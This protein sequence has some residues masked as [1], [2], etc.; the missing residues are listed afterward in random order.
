MNA[1]I[2]P[3][4]GRHALK[5]RAGCLTCKKRRV[6]CDQE[7]P[8]CHRCSKASQVCGGCQLELI[9]SALAQV[10]HSIV[11]STSTTP[12][13]AFSATQQVWQTYGFNSRKVSSGLSGA[14]DTDLWQ[15]LF[16]KVATTELPVRLALFALGTLARHSE[17]ENVQHISNCLCTYCRQTLKYYDRSISSLS[18]YLQ[19]T[20]ANDSVDLALVSC[21]LFTCIELYRTND[22]N[23]ITLV[24]KGSSILSQ[25]TEVNSPRCQPDPSLLNFVQSPSNLR[26]HV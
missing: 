24:E 5:P 23:A 11:I 21:V 19:K 10:S 22:R 9:S 26:G 12:L 6:K 13:S 8:A 7:R 3:N 1:N 14:F 18:D 2:R 15:R 17:S 4:L 25:T 20:P 16:L